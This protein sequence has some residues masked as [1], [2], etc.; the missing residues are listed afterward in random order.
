[1][2][3]EF[4]EKNYVWINDKVAATLDIQEG[5][6]LVLSSSIESVVIQ[7]YPTNKIAPQVLWFAHGFG[8]TSNEL[9]NAYGKGASDNMIIEDKF[10]K[11][12]G[13]ATMHETNITIR[14]L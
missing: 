7:A 14:K 5:D 10:E 1:M 11:I 13:C 3:K 2:L 8:T 12:Y 6:N 4:K 9:T